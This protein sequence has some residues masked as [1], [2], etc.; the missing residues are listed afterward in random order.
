MMP[1]ISSG[2][3]TFRKAVMAGGAQIQ[4]RLRQVGVQLP[5]LG[6]H[7]EDHVGNVKGDMGDEQGAQS[8]A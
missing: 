8:P 3:T 6:Q 1:G 7:G 4:G 2:S 5:Q